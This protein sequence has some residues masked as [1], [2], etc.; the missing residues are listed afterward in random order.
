M[1]KNFFFQFLH[2]AGYTSAKEFLFPLQVVEVGMYR[3]GVTEQIQCLCVNGTKP[4]LPQV[5]KIS[6]NTGPPS[7]SGTYRKLNGAVK[8]LSNMEEPLSEVC[9]CRCVCD[10]RCV[11]LYVYSNAKGNKTL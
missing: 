5:L 9:V 7:L 8:K 6:T 11:Y 1:P 2:S 10:C 3:Q 4:P